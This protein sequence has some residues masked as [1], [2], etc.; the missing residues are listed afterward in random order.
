MVPSTSISE[1][2]S[3]LP[4]SLSLFPSFSSPFSFPLFYCFLSQIRSLQTLTS[5]L[6]SI[7]IIF[8]NFIPFSPIRPITLPNPKPQRSIL[9]S[10]NWLQNSILSRFVGF[11]SAWRKRSNHAEAAAAAAAEFEKAVGFHFDEAAVWWRRW[12]RR[13]RLPPLRCWWCSTDWSGIRW[14]R[15][16]QEAPCEC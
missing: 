2:N 11:F 7:L 5:L 15:R 4:F 9:E 12:S 3:L 8:H 13:R 10:T 14:V 6:L 1:P 16:C